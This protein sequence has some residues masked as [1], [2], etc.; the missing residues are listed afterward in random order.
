ME[1]TGPYCVEI[2]LNTTFSTSEFASTVQNLSPWKKS[3]ALAH[4]KVDPGNTN[5]AYFGLFKF[6]AM[7]C[8]R[9]D[10]PNRVCL[11]VCLPTLLFVCSLIC[12]FSG[13][14][15]NRQVLSVETNGPFTHVFDF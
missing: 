4:S 5:L 1:A 3:C 12:L 14:Y 7:V 9:L 10:H 15:G 2:S 6:K 13:T 8:N 11:L